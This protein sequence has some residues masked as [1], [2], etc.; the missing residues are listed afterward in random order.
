MRL[1][2][3]FTLEEMTKSGSASRLRIDNTP[4]E[5]VV[6]NL[7]NLCIHVLEKV[8][9]N[10][11]RPVIVNSGYRSPAL[12]KVIG[13][14]KNSQ[15]MSGQAA[16]IEVPGIDNKF[17]FHWIR[18][19]LQ[20]DQLILEFYKPGIPDSGW[21]HVSWNPNTNRRQILEIK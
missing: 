3:H 8:R 2:Q 4:P 12:N 15:H 13:G 10:Y 19:N 11:G 6:K 14:S 16:D 18:D 21:V 17:L 5:D 1:S 9:L 7:T 20:F